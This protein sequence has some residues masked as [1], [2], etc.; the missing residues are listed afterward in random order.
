MNKIIEKLHGL[1]MIARLYIWQANFSNVIF[2]YFS[3]NLYFLPFFY[4]LINIKVQMYEWHQ[5]WGEDFFIVI[6]NGIHRKLHY[7][8][9]ICARLFLRKKYET[10]FLLFLVWLKAS[11][12]FKWMFFDELYDFLK[13]LV[14]RDI[15]ILSKRCIQLLTTMNA[16]MRYLNCVEIN[17]FVLMIVML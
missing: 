11:E 12:F 10:Y 7:S 4:I 6:R 2:L 14:S 5:M 3:A 9:P 1:E 8:I 16:M 13:C 17:H 15:S